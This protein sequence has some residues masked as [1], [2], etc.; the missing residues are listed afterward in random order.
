HFK[1]S[2]NILILLTFNHIQSFQLY[3]KTFSNIQSFCDLLQDFITNILSHSIAFL[4]IGFTSTLLLNLLNN[5]FQNKSQKLTHESKFIVT[6]TNLHWLGDHMI[7]CQFIALID[8]THNPGD[9]HWHISNAYKLLSH[10][11]RANRQY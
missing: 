10:G 3:F 8:I 11:G 6:E 9:D 2:L 1:E 4:S 5:K 7:A